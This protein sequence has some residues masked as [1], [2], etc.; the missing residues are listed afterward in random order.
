MNEYDREA[1]AVDGPAAGPPVRLL[2]TGGWDSTFQLLR[3]LLEQRATVVPYYLL[4]DRR[5][6]TTHELAAMERIREALGERHPSTRALLMPTRFR[7]VAA[8]ERDMDI[9]GAYTRTMQRT[10]I[11]RQYEWLAW[12]CAQ[13]GIDEIQL[14]IHRDD[15][16]HA[17]LEPFV[18]ESWNAGIRAHRF[19]A[20]AEDAADL[21][22]LFRHFA[23][24]LFEVSKQ[25]MEREAQA[26]GWQD[27]ME[28]TWFCHNPLHDGRPCGCCN[29]CLY[30][31][32][33]GLGHRLP[34]SSRVRSAVF[35][36]CLLP[37]K[38]PIVA[39]LETLGLRAKES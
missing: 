24:P 15:K 9:A 12:F 20:P 19:A 6:S 18:A 1:I 34:R 28:M 14:C 7:D 5:S 25:E 37:F 13:E 3:L 27:L 2:W 10:F 35:R 31:I 36:T 22:A 30:T 4:R 21:H 38:A 39:G 26:R 33:E 11:G 32:E 23:F 17:A 8:L 16:A 29:P